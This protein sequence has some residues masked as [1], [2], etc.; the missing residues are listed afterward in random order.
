MRETFD[1][2]LPLPSLIRSWYSE[3][4]G[5]PGFTKAAFEAVSQTVTKNKEEGRETLCSLMLDETAVRKQME[6]ANN[7]YHGF[8]DIGNAEVDDSAPKAKDAFVLMAV[9]VNGGWKTPL[10][11]F[12]I[13]GLSGRGRATLC[14]D[15]CTG[16]ITSA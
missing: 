12:L 16:C 8:V 5:D 14:E 11:Y 1:L 6:F 9:S 3:V 4:E 10:G 15:V 2:A 13:D 7:R